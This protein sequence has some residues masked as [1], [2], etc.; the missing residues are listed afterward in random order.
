MVCQDAHVSVPFI[1]HITS[2]EGMVASRFES[3]E[4]VPCSVY[5]PDETEST[6]SREIRTSAETVHLIRHNTEICP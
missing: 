4:R 2:E 5:I 6:E 3:C 1:C